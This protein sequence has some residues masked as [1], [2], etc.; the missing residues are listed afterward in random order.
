MNIEQNGAEVCRLANG[1]GFV[2]VRVP[3]H[4]ESEVA[5]LAVVS[6]YR[7]GTFVGRET[8]RNLRGSE[9]ID[10]VFRIPH[11]V[12]LD[13]EYLTVE[14]LGADDRGRRRTMWSAVWQARW[15]NG[16]PTLEMPDSRSVA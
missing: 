11:E 7:I 6:R 15:V 4:V 16:T 8:A 3:I 14:M 5:D 9:E 1:G 2:V 13:G 10:L 12:F